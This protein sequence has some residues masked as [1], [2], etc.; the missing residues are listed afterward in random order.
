VGGVSTAGVGQN[1]RLKDASVTR[2]ENQDSVT[3]KAYQGGRGT[4]KKR[5]YDWEREKKR[6]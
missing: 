4:E 6:I 3:C 5:M 1:V 2:G